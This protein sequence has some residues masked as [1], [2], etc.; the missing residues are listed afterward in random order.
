MKDEEDATTTVGKEVYEEK[1]TPRRRKEKMK[2]V[3]NGTAGKGLFLYADIIKEDR[4]KRKPSMK[5]TLMEAFSPRSRARAQ[6]EEELEGAGDEET[7]EEGTEDV[8]SESG[9]ESGGE[10][11]TKAT[12]ARAKLSRLRK[13]PP[14]AIGLKQKS[15]TN[16]TTGSLS[17]HKPMKRPSIMNDPRLQRKHSLRD[18]VQYPGRSLKW[19]ATGE[20]E[21]YADGTTETETETESSEGEHSGKYA[22]FDGGEEGEPDEQQTHM[23]KNDKEGEEEDGE[24]D[25]AGGQLT[26]EQKKQNARKALLRMRRL[27]TGFQAQKLTS[28]YAGIIK[29]VKRKIKQRLQVGQEIIQVERNYVKYMKRLSDIHDEL[30]RNQAIPTG[31]MKNK[32]LEIFAQFKI[33]H[34][35]HSTFSALLSERLEN[36]YWDSATSLLGDIFL[37]NTAFLLCYSEYYVSY[38]QC[39]DYVKKARASNAQVAQFFSVTEAQE[40]LGFLDLQS[41]LIMP[42]QHVPRYGL[43]LGQLLRATSEEHPDFDNTKRA[44]AHLRA[45]T[46]QLNDHSMMTANNAASSSSSSSSPRGGTKTPLACMEAEDIQSESSMDRTDIG[47]SLMT[48]EETRDLEVRF[49][50][51]MQELE[52]PERQREKMSSLP[53]AH[54]KLLVLGWEK[55]KRNKSKGKKQREQREQQQQAATSDDESTGEHDGKKILGLLKMGERKGTLKSKRQTSKRNVGQ[56]VEKKEK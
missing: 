39:V 14:G 1:S 54:K 45:T 30:E 38:P 8:P 32:L 16:V 43:L 27:S 2:T 3:S 34:Q 4:S 33:F 19:E 26:E 41:L 31:E 9:E 21:G 47:E 36:P 10:R 18:P 52:F 5:K 20:Q 24:G 42:V 17:V 44:Y 11:S 46:K 48:E 49:E 40:D 7:T 56:T 13:L 35:H 25:S 6:K 53:I 22:V 12:D 50:Q 51:L 15:M 28:Q 29:E 55:D 23:E 37:N